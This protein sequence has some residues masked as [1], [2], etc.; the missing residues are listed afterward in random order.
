MQLQ[1][2]HTLDDN[3]TLNNRHG[4]QVDFTKEATHVAQFSEFLDRSGMR[5]VATCP[6]VYTQY[7]SKRL[8]TME[9][10]YGAPLT[11][12]EAIRAVTTADPEQTL[13]NA[14]NTWVASVLYCETFHADVHAGNL[15][16]MK[17][18]F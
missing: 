2:L 14:L 8:L 6:Y 7:S 11:D 18:C 9:R 16:V 4:L 5:G 3:H 17:V 13:I 12:L 10:L 1:T 15:L